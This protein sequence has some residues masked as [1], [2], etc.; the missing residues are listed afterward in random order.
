[1]KYLIPLYFILFLS[2]FTIINVFSSSIQVTTTKPSTTNKN[3]WK[4]LK[5]PLNGTMVQRLGKEA[6]ETYNK[7]HPKKQLT[8]INVTRGLKAGRKEDGNKQ[9]KLR[10]FVSK[11]DNTASKGLTCQSLISIFNVTKNGTKTLVKSRLKPT[12]K[13]CN[14]NHNSTPSPN[15]ITRRGDLGS[16]QPRP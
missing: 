5:A 6:V 10:I 8:Y 1:M 9:I 14:L 2:I 12:T 16:F 4:K 15:A 3:K 13:I 11:T 7:N